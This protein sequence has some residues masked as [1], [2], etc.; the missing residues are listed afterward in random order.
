MGAVKFLAWLLLAALGIPLFLLFVLF[1][2]YVCA[3]A[4]GVSA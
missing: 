1:V 3:L 4:T 2:F